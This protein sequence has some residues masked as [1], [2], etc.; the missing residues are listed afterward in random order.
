MAKKWKPHRDP[1]N[2]WYVPAEAF[3]GTL[4]P[5]FATGPA[6]M[7]SGDAVRPLYQWSVK[8]KPIYLEDV[9]MTGIVAEKAHIRRLNHGLMT[10]VHIKNIN[11]CNY[12][13]FM[14]SHKHSPQ[15][16]ELLWHQVYAQ[17]PKPCPQPTVRPTKASKPV[18]NA[19]KIVTPT[20]KAPVNTG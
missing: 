10:N 18:V 9:Y 1:R 19:V 20:K 17:P 11:N 14:T 8:L 13:K 4:F 16:I 15:E 5:S 2:K 3:N 7:I 6:Y 12:S